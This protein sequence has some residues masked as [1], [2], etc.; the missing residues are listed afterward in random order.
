[1]FY[2]RSVAALV[3]VAGAC[4]GVSRVASASDFTCSVQGFSWI[5]GVSDDFLVSANWDTCIGIPAPNPQL[6]IYFGP[7]ALFLNGAFDN[8]ALPLGPAVLRSDYQNPR[9]KM[10]NGVDTFF[11]VQD[12]TYSATGEIGSGVPAGY[13]DPGGTVATLTLDNAVWNGPLTIGSS[14]DGRGRLVLRNGSVLPSVSF[15]GVAEVR[16]ET[17]TAL[18]GGVSGLNAEVTWVNTA[19]SSVSLNSG[20][21]F[22]ESGN[23]DLLINEAGAVL[24]GPG[25]GSS[26][27][28]RFDLVND[29]VIE[30]NGGS[31]TLSGLD[32][33]GDLNVSF[34]EEGLFSL[35]SVTLAGGADVPLNV[36][37]AGRVNLNS[38]SGTGA[39]VFTTPVGL[40][41][42]SGVE[43]VMRNETDVTLVSSVSGINAAVTW[44]NTSGSSLNLSSGTSFNESGDDDLLINEAGAVLVGPGVGSSSTIRFDLVNDGVIEVNGG[45]VTLSGLDFT[46]DLNV[47]FEEE[48]LFSLS[49]VT[50]AGGADVPLN[51]SGVGRV[52]LNSVRGTGALVFTTPVALD[53]GT[54]VETVLRNETDVTLVS[55]VSGINAAVTWINTSG[56]SLNLSSGT[57]FNES[58]DDDLLINEAGAVLVGPGAGSSS[59]IRF[60]L[61]NDGLIEVNGGS[62]TLSSLDFTGDL[63]VSF[64][65]EGLF[66]LSGVTL[67]GGADV[68]LNVSGTGRVN[69]NSVRGTGAVVFATPVELDIGSN[70]EAVMRNETDVTLVSSVSGSNAAVTWIN[71]AGSSAN[72]VPGTAFNGS[73]DDDLLVNETGA[74]LIGP[75][76]GSNS[77]IRFEF[78][79]RGEILLTGGSVTISYEEPELFEESVIVSG[80]GRLDFGSASAL[81]NRGALIPAPFDPAVNP[82][83]LTLDV[84]FIQNDDTA[85]FRTQVGSLAG[86]LTVLGVYDIGGMIEIERFGDFEPDGSEEFTILEA[87]FVTGVFGDYFTNAVP[88]SGTVARNVRTG[89]LEFDVEYTSTSV[90]V[91]NLSVIVPPC[92]IADLASPGGALTFADISAFLAGFAASSPDVDFA[93]P[94]GQWTFADISAFLVAFQAGCP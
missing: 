71:T 47:S 15:R 9:L 83:G 77:T 16:N 88:L 38:V 41:I 32:F 92:N 55:S 24:I 64:V 26:S 18:V 22:S 7:Q 89:D 60:D 5:G 8:W 51:V 29:G 42:G 1:M 11:T 20:T 66:S 68:P 10:A 35:S 46:G 40:D 3:S 57:S 17:D 21:S 75:G 31:V 56:S 74:V 27:T 52:N 25:A 84:P 67:A 82:G 50:L 19:G 59:T 85:L 13:P 33:T 2:S 91:K 63:N 90:I 45:S 87:D 30:V 70:V 4:L 79:N 86:K 81:F 49:S 28:I 93:E 43:A 94:F 53:I 65:E 73:G 78:E 72:L 61:V 58:G 44:I 34:V 76:A 6:E 80:V 48:G 39:L 54:G 69:L 12:A 37:G 62:V 23:D 36:S 14:G